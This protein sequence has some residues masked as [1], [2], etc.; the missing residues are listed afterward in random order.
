MYTVKTMSRVYKIYEK[1]KKGKYTGYIRCIWYIPCTKSF[2]YLSNIYQVT[3]AQTTRKN[4]NRH[5]T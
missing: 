4:A 3:D 2:K 1:G 5:H